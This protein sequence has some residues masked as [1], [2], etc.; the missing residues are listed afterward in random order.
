MGIEPPMKPDYRSLNSAQEEAER[1]PF[2]IRRYRQFARNLP[3]GVLKVLDVGCAN[4]R[5]GT[6][7]KRLRPDMELHGLDCLQHRLDRLPGAYDGHVCS[8]TTEIDAPDGTFDAIVAG[9]F[10]EHVTYSDGVRTLEEFWR[11]LR[12][13]GRLLMTTPYPDYLRWTLTGRE[14]VGGAHVSAHYPKQLKV[15]MTDAGFTHVRWRPSGR[16]TTLLGDRLPFLWF[17][18]SFLIVGDKL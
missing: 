2:T 4:G 5:G 10:I 17:Y 14:T 11:I 8:F 3:G 16:M 13:G 12:P 15:M 18:G 1:D 7:L 9:E 6:E